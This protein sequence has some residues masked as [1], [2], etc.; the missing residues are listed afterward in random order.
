MKLIT[1]HIDVVEIYDL[2]AQALAVRHIWNDIGSNLSVEWWMSADGKHHA[3]YWQ[4]AYYDEQLT[5][6]RNTGN[7]ICP[8]DKS[9]RLV[10]IA[11]LSGDLGFAPD[12][13]F[14]VSRNRIVLLNVAEN[15]I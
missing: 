10:F 5:R 12:S 8:Q 4:D 1:L 6:R 2:S 3:I 11:N 14:E 9:Q 7:M 13:Y 15:G